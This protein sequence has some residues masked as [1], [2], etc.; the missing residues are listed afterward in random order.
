MIPFRSLAGFL[1][2]AAAV[3][4]SGAWAQAKADPHRIEDRAR[5]ESIAAAHEAAARCLQAPGARAEV[6]VKQ[7][8]ADCRGLAVGIHCG[9]RSRPD[10]KREAAA[11]VAEH[12]RMAAVH[13]A[14][15]QCLAG[16]RSYRECQAELAK[17]CGGIGIGKYCGMRHVH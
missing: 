6:C 17:A 16:A 8:Q 2:A 15:A 13:A 14:A 4:Y 5:H 10:Q 7:L 11:R 3:A 12:Q 1:A 9:L